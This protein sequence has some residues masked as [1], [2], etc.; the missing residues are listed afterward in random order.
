MFTVS[1]LQDFDV[2]EDVGAHLGFVGEDVVAHRNSFSA[3]EE[4]FHLGVVIAVTFGA[5]TR[6]HFQLGQNSLV[7][8]RGI[9]VAPLTLMDHT[10]AHIATG[11]GDIF[12]AVQTKSDSLRSDTLQPTMRRVHRPMIVA[13]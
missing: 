12:N 5:N 2:V 4:G 11:Q 8:I 6:V 9:G 13:K 1:V 3:T 7:A 10:I